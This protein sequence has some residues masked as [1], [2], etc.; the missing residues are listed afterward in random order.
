M[1][2]F[3]PTY[4]AKHKLYVVY[5]T[6]STTTQSRAKAFTEKKHKTRRLAYKHAKEFARSK[7][8]FMNNGEYNAEY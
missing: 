5:Y 4:S 3:T 1:C 6:C 2:K 7:N 8:Y